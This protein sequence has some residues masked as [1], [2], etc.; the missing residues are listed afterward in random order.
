MRGNR[1]GMQ[2]IRGIRVGMQGI[3]EITVEMMGMRVIKVGMRGIKVGMM[4][5][6]VGMRGIRVGMR[7]IMVGMMR[8]RVGMGMS[9]GSSLC[10][11][12]RKGVLQK[13]SK[14]TG[15]H[16]C[17]SMISIKLHSKKSS[18]NLHFWECRLI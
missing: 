10:L 18:I 5:I 16:P 13:R 8:I 15:D 9:R 17:R 7:G 2:G 1:V 4:G 14:F 6:R 11:F 12:F 3:L